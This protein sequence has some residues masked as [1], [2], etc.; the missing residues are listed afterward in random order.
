[1]EKQQRYIQIG[2]LICLLIVGA[3]VAVFWPGRKDTEPDRK[4]VTP[5]QDHRHAPEVATLH[6]M[7]PEGQ[8]V[9]VADAL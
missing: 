7:A 1:M 3:L 6:E 4:I 2:N 5:V 9:V 8:A